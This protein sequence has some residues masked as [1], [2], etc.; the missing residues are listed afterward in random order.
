MPNWASILRQPSFPQVWLFA[1]F[2]RGIEQTSLELLWDM[3]VLMLRHFGQ[4]LEV[5][6]MPYSIMHGIL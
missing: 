6:G 2:S 4:R 1:H 5:D 3:V